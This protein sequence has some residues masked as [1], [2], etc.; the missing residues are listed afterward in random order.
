M[1]KENARVGEAKLAESA[2]KSCASLD[3]LADIAARHG[4]ELVALFYDTLLCNDEARRFLNHTVVQERLSSSLVEWLTQ[5]LSGQD[6]RDSPAQQVRQKIIGEVHARIKI[7]VHLVMTGAMVI[8]A[9]LAELVE[10]QAVDPSVGLRSLHVAHARMDTAIMLISR[11]YM[12]DAVARERLD[13]AYRLFSLDQDA[14][15]E[16]EAQ[17]ASLMEWSQNTFF[18]LLQGGKSGQMPRL[19]DSPFGLWLRHRAQFMFEQSVPFKDVARLVAHIDDALLPGL[20]SCGERQGELPA[21]ADLRAA[22]DEISFLIADLFQTLS[23]LEGGRDPLT[24]ALNR[25]F[26]PAILGREVTFAE[27]HATALSVMLVDIDHFKSIND[28]HGHQVGD[29][30]LRQVAQVIVES[31]RPTDFVFRYGGEEFLIVLVET[32]IDEAAKVA[33]RI[34]AGMEGRIFETGNSGGGLSVTASF[35]IAQ[36]SGHPD[37][38]YL[39]KAA[40]EALYRAKGLG[41]NRVELAACKV[42]E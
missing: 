33:E 18:A 14:A 30:V 22:V 41:R 8:K 29:E 19:S 13:E 7:P 10:A 16:K 35:G 6:I 15:V 25:R 42:G 27:E 36:H 28:R 24:R 31:A 23:T 4:H 17:R 39:I 32:G 1:F 5:L 2:A 34:R 20:A 3:L 38:K 21:L 12:K 37:Q 40:D 9:R 11:S 26:L